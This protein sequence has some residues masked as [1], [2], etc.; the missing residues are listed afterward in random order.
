MDYVVGIDP[1][2]KGG[3]AVINKETHKVKY[4][5]EFSNDK[6]IIIKFLKEAREFAD[7]VYLE[8]AISVST[9]RTI[10]NNLFFINGFITGVAECLGYEVLRFHPSHWKNIMKTCS[11]KEVSI[12]LAIKLFPEAKEEIEYA[13]GSYKDGLGEA[14]LIAYY[15]I[16]YS[17]YYPETDQIKKDK[18]KVKKTKQCVIP[19]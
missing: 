7:I 2:S 11:D 3:F 9:N 19:L 14:L 12:N 18:P 6:E 8:K 17:M 5:K 16:V 4:I 13:H 1:G 15:G 10:C